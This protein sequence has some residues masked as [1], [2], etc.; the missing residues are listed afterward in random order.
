MT[1]TVSLLSTIAEMPWRPCD[2]MTIRSQPF[3]SSGINNRLVGMLKLDLDGLACDACCL[4]GVGGGAEDFVG[5]LCMRALYSS[6]LSSMH[7]RVGR[8]S[9]KRRQDSQHD[10]WCRSAWPRRWRAGQLSWRV[11]TRPLVSGCWYT[12]PSP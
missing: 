5:L 12:S 7:L 4:R 9:M 1:L 11:P 10:G 3:D 6:R 2:A 8:E